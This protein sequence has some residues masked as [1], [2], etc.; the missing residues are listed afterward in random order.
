M[1]PYDEP[2]II[3]GPADFKTLVSPEEPAGSVLGAAF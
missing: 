3:D 1:G 2:R